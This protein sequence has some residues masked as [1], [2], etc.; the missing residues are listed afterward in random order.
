H[1]HAAHGG[2]DEGE[3]DEGVPQRVRQHRA[4]RGRPRAD[5]GDS[6]AA[7]LIRGGPRERAVGRPGPARHG[8]PDRAIAV[9]QRGGACYNAVGRPRRWPGS[10][11]IG[12]PPT[13][14]PAPSGS[15]G[16]RALANALAKQGVG[17]LTDKP[18]AP[19]PPT[20]TPPTEI[21]QT[22][23][24]VVITFPEVL[25]AFNSAELTPRA[26]R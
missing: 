19:P 12:C 14:P 10:R 15:H 26:R 9:E 8:C 25:F 11:R 22:P 17:Q 7:R 4:R 20:A 5:V 13:T 16:D 23:R 21:R 6:R 3:L 24:G 2:A 18:P 1:H